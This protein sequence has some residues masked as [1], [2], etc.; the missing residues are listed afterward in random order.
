MS[1]PLFGEG[2][3]ALVIEHLETALSKQPF[4]NKVPGADHDL[5]AM[6]ADTAA[7]QRDPDALR[8]YA[9]LAEEAAVRYSHRLYL[10]IAHRAWGVLHRLSGDYDP[11]EARFRQA[12]DEFDALGAR[13]QIGRT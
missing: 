11:A 1:H 3:F 2:E 13:W 10:G 12:L 9:P 7:R 4:L 5:A 8:K 6:M